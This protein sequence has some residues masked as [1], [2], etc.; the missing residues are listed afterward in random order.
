[1]IYVKYR[2]TVVDEQF[3]QG[4][5]GRWDYSWSKASEFEVVGAFAEKPEGYDYET[6]NL[7][8]EVGVGQL[9]AWKPKE[10]MKEMGVTISSVEEVEEYFEV[11]EQ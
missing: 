11:E 3:D 5:G 9:S 6:F 10:N 1:M 2:E 4:D 7:D 8:F